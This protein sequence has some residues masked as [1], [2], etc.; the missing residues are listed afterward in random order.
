MYF[1]LAVHKILGTIVFNYF[2]VH[3]KVSLMVTLLDS[4]NVCFLQRTIFIKMKHSRMLM[5]NKYM[6]RKTG[7]NR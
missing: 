3:N 4:E 7:W 1:Y 2:F 5:V 6:C